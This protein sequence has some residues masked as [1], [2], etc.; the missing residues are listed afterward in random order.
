M[1]GDLT[2]TVTAEL[3]QYH[4]KGGWHFVTLPVDE[5]EQI[6]FFAGANTRGWGSVRVTVTIGESVWKTSLFPESKAG[7]YVLPIKAAVRK[8]E[9]LGAGDRVTLQ[10]DIRV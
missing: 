9:N 7:T 1:I 5:A 8:K 2:F 4:G 10:L 6:K 3:W